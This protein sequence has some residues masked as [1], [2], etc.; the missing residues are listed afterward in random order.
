MI[1]S[2]APAPLAGRTPDPRALFTRWLHAGAT[3][4][5]R[6]GAP[7]PDGCERLLAFARPLLDDL[8][9]QLRTPGATLI[10]SGPD[11]RTLIV[12]QDAHAT[13]PGVGGLLPR[14]SATATTWPTLS[15]V[16]TPIIDPTGGLAGILDLRLD[17]AR[18]PDGSA[19]ALL[20]LTAELIEHR[21]INTLT[22][23]FLSMGFHSRLDLLGGPLEAR[24]VFDEDGRLYA[25]NAAARWLLH[26]YD[27]FPELSCQE[28]FTTSW[29]HLVDWTHISQRTPFPIRTRSGHTC[30]ALT[31]LQPPAVRPGMAIAAPRTPE[32]RD[33]RIDVAAN[34]LEDA[35]IRRVPA[36][37]VGAPG[38]GRRHLLRTVTARR[39]TVS[40]AHS[41]DGLSL[42]AD[43][44]A[45]AGISALAN[46]AD[47]ALRLILDAEHLPAALQCQLF[48]ACRS[49]MP[50]VLFASDWPGETGAGGWLAHD[51]FANAG[52]VLITLPSLAARSDF[53]NLVRTLVREIAPDR[54]ID[55]SKAAITTLRR[56]SWPGNFNELLNRLRL[57]VALMPDD[58]SQLDD[59]DLACWH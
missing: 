42:A 18:T 39:R 50:L 46:P 57:V 30:V 34:A 48:E 19:L 3:R 12:L 54:C 58:A 24:A 10:L 4:P 35:L 53:A 49:G 28:G 14:A 7:R 36:L 11:G 37:I 16:A 15:A 17:H 1:T 20:Q 9:A 40:D 26:L 5:S 32:D 31:R 23:G 13:A 56:H 29:Q 55:I 45:A 38:S 59:S 47:P 41:V 25:C 6:S 33:P 8:L 22:D 2:P 51:A 27:E 43:P 21:L 44:D 52:G